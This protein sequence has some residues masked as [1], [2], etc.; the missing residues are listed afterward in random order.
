MQDVNGKTQENDAFLLT[1][2]GHEIC[3]HTVVVS[4]PSATIFKRWT[5]KPDLQGRPRRIVVEK[6]TTI[7]ICTRKYHVPLET[8]NPQKI[9]IQILHASRIVSVFK[10]GISFSI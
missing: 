4:C 6:I 1:T 5:R 3:E 2:A 7:A 10:S 9:V 8:A